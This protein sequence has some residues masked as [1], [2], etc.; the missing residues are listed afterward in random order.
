MKFYCEEDLE[1]GNFERGWQIIEEIS[2][3]A[4]EEARLLSESPS[5]EFNTIEEAL[6]F[7]NAIPFEQFEH[8]IKEKYGM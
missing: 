4:D 7:Y 5:P 1:N 3:Q 2:R 8:E 6:K